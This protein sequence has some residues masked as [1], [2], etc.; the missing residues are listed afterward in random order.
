MLL[1]TRYNKI[2]ERIIGSAMRVHT[3]L[4]TGFQEVIYQRS[5]AVE[6]ER[7]GLVFGRE[8]EMPLYYKGGRRRVAAG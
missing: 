3:I 5:L 6:M 4:G 1:D 2:T 7:K 8:L